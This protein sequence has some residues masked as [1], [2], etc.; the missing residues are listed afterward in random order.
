[1][2]QVGGLAIGQIP[3]TPGDYLGSSRTQLLK[4]R[5]IAG[6]DHYFFA[7]SFMANT[8]AIADGNPGCVQ[9]C[10]CESVTQPYIRDY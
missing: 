7:A 8:Q 2:I 3:T 9:N 1:M 10:M 5:A 6:G 4:D